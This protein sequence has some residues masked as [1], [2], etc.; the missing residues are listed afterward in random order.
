MG[1]FCPWDLSSWAPVTRGSPCPPSPL[2]QPSFVSL[3]LL[4]PSV[5]ED[6]L[7]SLFFNL[8]SISV[9]AVPDGKR[10]GRDFEQGETLELVGE[11]YKTSVSCANLRCF[12]ITVRNAGLETSEGCSYQPA[13]S[14]SCFFF[15]SH[16]C[17]FCPVCL[18]ELTNSL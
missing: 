14:P 13:D 18:K 6:I 8:L 15:L 4:F 1:P 9:E 2:H 16:L 11:I 5:R 17:S 12:G 7:A 3:G 10:L